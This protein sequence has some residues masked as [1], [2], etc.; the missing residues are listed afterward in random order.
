MITFKNIT[1][2]E[3]PVIKEYMKKHE[4]KGCE[5]SIGNLYMWNQDH[6]LTYSVVDGHIVF[7]R[8]DEQTARY[9]TP[10]IEKTDRGL[11]E[12]LLADAKER[13]KEI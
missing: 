5:F 11:I 13:G 3:L 8:S 1:F 6:K 12:K 9:S 7:F 2:E 10:T 4:H